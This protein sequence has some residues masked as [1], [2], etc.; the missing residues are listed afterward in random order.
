MDQVI[1]ADQLNS[2]VLEDLF[3]SMPNTNLGIAIGIANKTSHEWNGMNALFV[4]GKPGRITLTE[5]VGIDQAALFTATKRTGRASG[6]VGVITF[7]IPDD[8]MTVAVMFSVPFFR[9]VYGN[10][11]DAKVYRNMKEADYDMWSRMYNQEPFKGDNGWH[12]KEIG[13][14]YHVK[15]HMTSS[16]RC[17]LQLKIWNEADKDMWSRMY[18][19]EP[20]EDDNGWHEKEIVEGYHVQGIMTSSSRCNCCF[21]RQRLIRLIERVASSFRH[22]KIVP[23]SLPKAN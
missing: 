6:S 7:F 4:S 11:W 1:P 14:G 18:N 9:L 2:K 13:E 21:E 8:N 3:D 5:F 23:S 22:R 17:K 19:Q 10:W 20:F 12:E 16:S 15:G